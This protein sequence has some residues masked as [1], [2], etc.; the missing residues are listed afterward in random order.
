MPARLAN[1][2]LLS[3][4]PVLSFLFFYIDLLKATIQNAAPL[5]RTIVDA[6]PERPSVSLRHRTGPC[7]LD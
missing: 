4:L 7:D 3:L 5:L 6:L 1:A 2:L